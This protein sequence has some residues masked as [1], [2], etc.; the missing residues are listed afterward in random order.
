[1]DNKSLQKIASSDIVLENTQENLKA[2]FGTLLGVISLLPAEM[3]RE[4]IRFNILP[5]LS[6]MKKDGATKEQIVNFYWEVPE[7]V[8]VFESLGWDKKDLEKMVNK[9]K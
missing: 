2:A 3:T 9:A 4:T 1:M 5:D 7:F 6:K 8:Q